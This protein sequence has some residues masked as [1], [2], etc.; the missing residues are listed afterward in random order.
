MGG[1]SK[2]A[3]RSG[4]DGI[5]PAL[6]AAR[7]GAGVAG[8]P[9]GPPGPAAPTGEGWHP[10]A[11]VGGLPGRGR[12]GAAGRVVVPACWPHGWDLQDRGRRQPGPA[13]GPAWQGRVLPAGR[14]LHHHPGRAWRVACGDGSLGRG[15][16]PGRAGHPG[17][18]TSRVGQPE[19]RVRRQ[20]P[21]PHRPGAGGVH[22]LG[23]PVVGGWRLAGRLPRARAGRAVGACRG[24]GRRRG[25]EPAGPGVSGA[26][27]GPRA[28]AYPG[29]GP[30]HQGS[31]HRG[32]AGYNR[33]Q[34]GLRALVEQAIGH[35]ANAWSLRR[36]RGC[37][38][39]SGTS[40]GPLAP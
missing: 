1:F 13:A 2:P 35:L 26:G 21:R 20:A 29:R 16:V 17:A 25:G 38:P 32:A 37:C 36:W 9:P 23:R 6:V 22:H 10:A 7:H 39:G 34:A 11:V 3:W 31:A 15:G 30:P 5:L 28:L 8:P 24:A 12:R 19:G 14:H 40:L 4:P 27:Q 18:A 33:V